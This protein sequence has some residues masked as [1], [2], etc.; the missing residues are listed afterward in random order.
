MR[1][2]CIMDKTRDNET[3]FCARSKYFAVGQISFR[4][5]E[6]AA[7]QYFENFGLGKENVTPF[8]AVMASRQ[9]KAKVL[10]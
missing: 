3:E 8:T 4:P 7:L 6:A 5:G 10:R 9:S 1:H 2:E